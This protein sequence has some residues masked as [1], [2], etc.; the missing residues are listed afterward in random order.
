MLQRAKSAAKAQRIFIFDL[1]QLILASFTSNLHA[2]VRF[3][4][5][6][7]AG[8]SRFADE[9]TLRLRRLV[10]TP[11]LAQQTTCSKSRTPA[12]MS[13]AYDNHIASLRL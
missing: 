10:G 7:A 5:L 13:P 1:L 12:E 2:G 3:A 11:I 9:A 8:D 6:R 4:S